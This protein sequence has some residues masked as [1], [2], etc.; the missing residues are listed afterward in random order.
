MLRG[1]IVQFDMI[2][3]ARISL[4]RLKK[5]KT[6]PHN[7]ASTIHECPNMALGGRYNTKTKAASGCLRNSTSKPHY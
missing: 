7:F 5:L 1:S 3:S 6:E 2:G 4:K